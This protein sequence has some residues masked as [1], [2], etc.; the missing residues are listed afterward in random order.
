[1][2]SPNRDADTWLGAAV[3]AFLDSCRSP[4]TTAAYRADLQHFLH[5]CRIGANAQNERI[6]VEDIA[7]YRAACE[8]QGAATAT[9]ARRLSAIASFGTF[10]RAHGDGE[11]LPP[12]RSIDRPLPNVESTTLL[13][14]DAQA[15]TLLRAA[16]GLNDRAGALI[17]LLMLDGLKIGD[18]VNA[19]ANM[20]E[21]RPPNVRL[22]LHAPRRR[23]LSLHADTARAISR[24]LGHRRTG[25]LLVSERRGRPPERMTRF[26]INSIVKQTATAAELEP[27]VSANT[28]RRRYVSCADADATTSQA[29]SRHA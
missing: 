22:T 8:R 16:D 13:L 2:E 15:E 29:P 5:W 27:S 18:V 12:S 28:L 26:G 6:T 17:R 1:M 7:S 9:V 21:G 14:T 23:T 25:P 19:D 4:N 20:V 10:A 24:Y 11:M 3:G